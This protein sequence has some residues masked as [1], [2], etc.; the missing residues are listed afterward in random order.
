MFTIRM[1]V[2][3]MEEFQDGLL[4]KRKENTLS[5]TEADLINR[6]AKAI[7][8]LS[9]NPK[10]P[11]LKTHEIAPLSEKYG[12]KIVQLALPR[13]QEQLFQTGVVKQTDSIR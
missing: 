13:N 3:E 12:F 6:F 2:P 4:Q 11:G 10:H 8:F 9:S 1:G 7:L 5:K